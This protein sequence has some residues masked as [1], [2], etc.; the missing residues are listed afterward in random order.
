MNVRE[1]ENLRD[2]AKADAF[3]AEYFR[4]LAGRIAEE[5]A[6]RVDI[7]AMAEDDEESIDDLAVL[8]L[9]LVAREFLD[10]VQEQAGKFSEAA[11]LPSPSRADVQAAFEDTA[12]R[13]RDQVVSRLRSFRADLERA[14]D[15]ADEAGAAVADL[16]TESFVRSMR[17]A[18]AVV[19][20]WAARQF[21]SLSSAAINQAMARRR[22]E[23]AAKDPGNDSDL[24]AYLAALA[25]LAATLTRGGASSGATSVEPSGVTAEDEFF[26]WLTVQDD[27]VCHEDEEPAGTAPY[28]GAPLPAGAASSCLS[29]HGLVLVRQ[30]WVLLGLPK[31][32]RLRCSRHG[33][34]NCRCRLVAATAKIP[35]GPVIT[36]DERKRA[37]AEAQAEEIDVTQLNLTGLLDGKPVSW[38]SIRVKKRAPVPAGVPA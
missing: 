31:D 38:L 2:A 10:D 26:R 5:I 25:A 21:A 30:D 28:S 17:E 16:F 8:V 29:R 15:A 33:S 9:A 27:A 23:A 24:L 1:G 18:L 22:A 35:T 6:R 36:T 14:V 12:E 3:S 11:G 13:I 4:I 37:R 34:R 19:L 32:P 20:A 7:E